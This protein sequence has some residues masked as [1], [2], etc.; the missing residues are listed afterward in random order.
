[1]GDLI[2]CYVAVDVAGKV[3]KELGGMSMLLRAL[4]GII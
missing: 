2:F 1:L 3:E 4:T